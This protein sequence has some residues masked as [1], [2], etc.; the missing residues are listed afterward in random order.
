MSAFDHPERALS[1][2]D[3]VRLLMQHEPALRAFARSLLPD[4]NL[5]D[6]VI[7]DASIVLW[8]KFDQ[9]RDEPGFLPW[10][11]VV[12]RFKCLSAIGKLGRDRHVFSAG[13]L[14]LLADEAESIDR[15]GQAA[16]MRALRTCLDKFSSAHQELLLAPYAGDGRVKVLAEQSGR[17]ANALYKL[18]G[19]LRDKLSDCIRQD[20]ELQNS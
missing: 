9:L 13:V 6:E 12:V 2:S 16:R 10:T 7:Q 11:K 15:D 17:S 14:E 19:R 20:L 3:F 18:L 5:V 8:E 4:W 1:Q